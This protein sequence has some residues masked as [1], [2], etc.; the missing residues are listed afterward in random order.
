V[1]AVSLVVGLVLRFVLGGS[2]AQ[3]RPA[4]R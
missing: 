4:A 2:T 3:E 1:L